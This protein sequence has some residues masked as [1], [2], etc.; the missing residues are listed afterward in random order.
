MRTESAG[1]WPFAAPG[2]PDEDFHREEC[3]IT[4]EEVRVVTLSKA[5]LRAGD[6][7][8]DIGAGSGSIAVEAGLLI[9][10]GRVYA[11]EK[12]GYRAGLCRANAARFDADNVIVVD[13]AAPQALA[14]LPPPDRVIIGGSSGALAAILRVVDAR[15][16]PGGR[17]VI[18]AVTVETLTEG[19]EELAAL[20]Y[21]DEVVMLNVARARKTA[22]LRMWQACNPVCI[23]AATKTA[24][25][26]ADEPGGGEGGRS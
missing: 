2:I 7:V 15:L 3:P 10:P 25:R 1:K 4:K 17:I 8:Y 20:G 24:R 14:G 19:L 12:D 18:Q 21:A 9:R 5:R 13:G 23:I 22:G 11:I 26:Q 6:V 16:R